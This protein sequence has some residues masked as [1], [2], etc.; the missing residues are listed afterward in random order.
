MIVNLL[1]SMKCHIILCVTLGN[2]RFTG[3]HR[4]GSRHSIWEGGGGHE[5]RPNAKG[6]VGSFGGQKLIYNKIITRKI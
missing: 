5:M 1:G 4:G 6:T 2:F 3:V